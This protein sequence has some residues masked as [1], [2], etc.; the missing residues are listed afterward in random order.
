M[1]IAENQKWFFLKALIVTLVIFNIGIYMGYKLEA[2][3][4]DK[5]N[6]L[7]LESELLLLDQEI[8]RQAFEIADLNCDKSVQANISPKPRVHLSP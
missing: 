5:I 4:A 1:K 2:S 7:Y 3:R 8:Q 6:Q